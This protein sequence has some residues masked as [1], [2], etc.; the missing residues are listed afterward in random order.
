[1]SFYQENTMLVTIGGMFLLHLVHEH[2]RTRASLAA[3]P[4]ILPG[5]NQLPVQEANVL[6]TVDA[7]R[8]K[9]PTSQHRPTS[10]S[11]DGRLDMKPL[12]MPAH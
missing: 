2:I 3:H 10:G 6:I 11:G 5:R 12:K 1:M 9:C 4:A 8:Q 7:C